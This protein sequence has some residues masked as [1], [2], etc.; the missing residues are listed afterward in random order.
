[1]KT[2]PFNRGPN[3][4]ITV[5]CA[6]GEVPVH[7]RCAYCRHCA[8]IR[9]GKRVTPNPITQTYGKVKRSMSVDEELINAGL[10]FNTLAADPRAEAI[11]CADEKE[12]GY[13]RITAR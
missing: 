3:D 7:T 13:A 2:L 10:M 11:E 12:T 4:R 8:G 1:M 6:T 9:I 5:Q